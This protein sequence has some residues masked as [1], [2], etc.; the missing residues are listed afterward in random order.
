MNEINYWHNCW[1]MVKVV[2]HWRQ[3]IIINSYITTLELQN[4]EWQKFKTALQLL[5]M[6]MSTGVT[7]H[8]SKLYKVLY[9]YLQ[10]RHYILL[11]TLLRYN[12]RCIS[13]LHITHILRN[14][15]VLTYHWAIVLAAKWSSTTPFTLLRVFL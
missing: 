12:T 13:K 3:A 4:K 1:L 8:T 5:G 14:T 7:N 11:T 15:H 9:S 6:L 2:R 10:R